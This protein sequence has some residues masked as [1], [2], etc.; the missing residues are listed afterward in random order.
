MLAA[1]LLIL[2]GCLTLPGDV[3]PPVSTVTSVA[4]TPTPT[5]PV[6]PTATPSPAPTMPTVCDA[7]EILRQVDELLAGRTF[8]AHY[9]TMN[10]ELTL[11]I[12]LVDPELDPQATLNDLTEN[13]QQAMQTGISLFQEVIEQIPCVREVFVNANPMIVD[14]L[15]QGWY[16]DIIPIRAFPETEDL[17][18]DELLDV[19]M[20]S[21]F[22]SGFYR[23]SP[24]QT[25]AQSS[26][27]DACTWPEAR[28]AIGEHFGTERRNAAAYLIVGAPTELTA[29]TEDVLVEVQWDVQTIEEMDN[30]LILEHLNHVA[31]ALSCLWP[32]VD[33]AEVFVVDTY[34]Q[35]A[36]FAA[37]PG[38]LIRE[39]VSPLPPDRVLIR[40]IYEEEW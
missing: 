36:V 23:R 39:Q 14:R 24:P 21:G 38:S 13:N 16:R 31:G 35:F 30:D 3:P 11:S 20:S 2:S 33:R 10:R 22:R 5:D 9:L 32:P 25:A 34:G 40:N 37:V 12:W 28:A 1:L 18:D 7:N 8:E 19:L 27:V 17:T 29:H 26:P 15:Y 4:D 6:L